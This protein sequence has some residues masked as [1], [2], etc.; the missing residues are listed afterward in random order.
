MTRIARSIANGRLISVGISSTFRAASRHLEAVVGG[1]RMRSGRQTAEQHQRQQSGARRK[2]SRC[3]AAGLA[4]N[5]RNA[6]V[7]L[8]IGAEQR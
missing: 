8:G 5:H 3:A 1:L 4:G 6:R 2:S 7:D